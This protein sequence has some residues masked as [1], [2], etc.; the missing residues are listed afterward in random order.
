M[1]TPEWVQAAA[2][3]SATAT[4]TLGYALEQYR[5]K[6]S[7]TQETFAAELG[8]TLET[9]QSLYLCRRPEGPGFAQQLATITTS[10]PVSSEKLE[11]VLHQVAG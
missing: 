11:A 2:A 9:L 4:W 6:Q 10:L 1:T 7:L 3:R 8:C 5:L